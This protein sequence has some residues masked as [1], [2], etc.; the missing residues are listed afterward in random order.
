M[1]EKLLLSIPETAAT[2][3]V[4]VR[5]IHRW[6]ALGILPCVRLGRRKLCKLSDVVRFSEQGVTSAVVR[7]RTA[8]GVV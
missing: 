7:E 3:G 4:G 5:S 6:V 1:T 2:L 8:R